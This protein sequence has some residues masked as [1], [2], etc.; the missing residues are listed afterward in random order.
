MGQNNMLKHYLIIGLIISL[1]TLFN[2]CSTT[3]MYALGAEFKI[4]NKT[5]Y[6][7]TFEEPLLQEYNVL[8]NG[9]KVFTVTQRTGTRIK[10]ALP[11]DYFSQFSLPGRDML[12][13]KFNGN[14]CL[15]MKGK[16]GI[17]NIR[18]INSF[19]AEKLGNV[20]YKFTYTFT[21]ADY[22]R[23]VACP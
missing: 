13:V 22:N 8:A 23:A 12:L 16:E 1:L 20:N 21:E 15:S 10:R 4:V 19:V 6:N 7:I 11:S 9:T 5:N 18:D 3:N 14:M 2:S 17:N